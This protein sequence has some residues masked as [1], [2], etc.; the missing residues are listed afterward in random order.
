[1]IWEKLSIIRGAVLTKHK[2]IENNILTK[3]V[4]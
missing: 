4:K 1:M 3:Y 2:R